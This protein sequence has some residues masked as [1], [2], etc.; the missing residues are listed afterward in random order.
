MSDSAAPTWQESAG[1]VLSGA[2]LLWRRE[3]RAAKEQAQEERSSGVLAQVAPYDPLTAPKSLSGFRQAMALNEEMILAAKAAGGDLTPHTPP[4]TRAND[5]PGGWTILNQAGGLQFVD[6]PEYIDHAPQ[7]HPDPEEAA[8]SWERIQRDSEYIFLVK[9]RT[10]EIITPEAFKRGRE[11]REKLDTQSMELA[12]ALTSAG[13][14]AFDAAMQRKAP[15]IVDPIGRHLLRLQPFRRINFLPAVAAQRRAPMLKHLEQF[16]KS[17]PK[18]KMFT[19]TRGQRVSLSDPGA[20]RA[21]IEDLHRR[22]SRLNAS[23]A[24]RKYGCRLEFRATEAGTLLRACRWPRRA[25]DHAQAAL[26]GL[27]GEDDPG[28]VWLH[29]HAHCFAT[30]K[31][32][33][34]PRWQEF[35]KGVWKKWAAHWDYGRNIAD[36]REACKYPVKPGDMENARMTPEEVDALFRELQGLR[37]VTP[38]S[39]LKKRIRFRR[40]IAL[41]GVKWRNGNGDLD[42]RF[43]PDWN[44]HGQRA[45]LVEVSAFRMFGRWL[46]E[47]ERLAAMAAGAVVEQCTRLADARAAKA[48]LQARERKAALERFLWAAQAGKLSLA[49]AEH[50]P[51]EA[52][53]WAWLAR[54]FVLECPP[55]AAEQARTARKALGRVARAAQHT[56]PPRNQIVAR[57][58]PA[59][60]FDRVSRPALLVWGFDG[61]WDQLTEQPVCKSIIEAARPMLEAAAQEL[62]SEGRIAGAFHTQSSHQS[63]NCPFGFGLEIQ[64]R[65]GVT[66]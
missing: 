28:E 56:P 37:L 65:E 39:D 29:L 48:A 3:F 5:D 66:A 31:R 61:R 6:N 10:G 11:A 64:A 40:E 33:L 8:A 12:L 62:A 34:G 17:R 4:D 15:M 23:Q 60:Y 2:S 20:V 14:R 38:M 63:H 30:F 42:L 46:D 47:E 18:T 24:F 45:R 7:F 49:A 50:D 53:A 9:N 54:W 55:G 22:L 1:P 44:A 43:R 51:E 36:A 25:L 21:A 13:T 26:P 58:A 27:P 57:L 52:A 59:P 19:F 16:L 41:K 35:V 32:D